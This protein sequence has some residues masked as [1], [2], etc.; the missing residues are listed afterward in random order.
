MSAISVHC[1][2]VESPS[3]G[4][5]SWHFS[6]ANISRTTKSY[7]FPLI[8]IGDTSFI[9]KILKGLSTSTHYS[10]Q[11]GPDRGYTIDFLTFCQNDADCSDRTTNAMATK[12]MYF[13]DILNSYL[14]SEGRIFKGYRSC[15]ITPARGYNINFVNFS[16]NG[17]G[18]C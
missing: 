7:K 16:P 12:L 4:S 3:R 1:P 9:Y 11:R 2:L 18:C 8:N 5:E 14:V 6:K 17:T 13:V 10:F 15:R